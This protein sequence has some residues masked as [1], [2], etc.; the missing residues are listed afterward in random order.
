MDKFIRLL[1]VNMLLGW[2]SSCSHFT[3]NQPTPDQGPSTISVQ[4]LL[5]QYP[6]SQDVLFTTLV[7]NQLWKATFNQQ[8]QH[9][10][11][12][13]NADRLLTA[14]QLV[15]GTLADSLTRLLAPT[16]MAGGT[17]SNPYVRRYTDWFTNKISNDPP[18]NV[19][20]DYTWQ[21]QRYTVVWT[22]ARPTIRQHFYNL[23][24]RPYQLATYQST[25]LTD[26]P[27]VIQQRLS[28]QGLV[29]SN[30]IV[31]LDAYGNRQYQLAV[32]QP[33]APSDEQY[34]QLT[35]NDEGQLL[36]ATNQASANTL[37]YQQLDQLPTAIQDY[38]RRPELAGFDLS[39]GGGFYGYTCRYTY[40]TLTTYRVCLVNGLQ[41][42]QLFFSD[43][44]QLI[45][46]SFLVVGN[47]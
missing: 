16:V 18:E 45:S 4:A 29:F 27:A 25:R 9:Y 43:T 34:W 42:W 7:D 15:E 26:L 3:D 37:F 30:A 47:F 14:D 12:L 11:A 38:L 20:A 41:A 36:V 6:Q 24:L 10:Q 8:R 22:L 2:G 1:W 5:R 23:E 39:R 28:D 44:G 21:Q 35:Y 32:Q 40:G 33:S 46:R 19:Y 31:Q 13:V 17:F